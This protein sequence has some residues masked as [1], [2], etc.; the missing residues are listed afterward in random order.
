MILQL[1]MAVPVSL[2]PPAS[3]RDVNL[4]V[5]GELAGVNHTKN[6]GPGAAAD[7]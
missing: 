4:S 6:S 7:S 2:H 3:L 1:Q 5:Y